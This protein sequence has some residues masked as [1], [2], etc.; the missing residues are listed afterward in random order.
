MSTFIKKDWSRGQ[1]VQDTDVDRWEN[2]I[3]DAH[4]EIEEL[5]NKV[6]EIEENT[7]TVIDGGTF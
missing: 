5:V 3:Y 6:K 2:G 1:I 4:V 7:P